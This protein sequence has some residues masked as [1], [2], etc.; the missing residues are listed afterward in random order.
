MT[1]PNR[2][3]DKTLIRGCWDDAGTRRDQPVS[4]TDPGV[5]QTRLPVHANP[6]IVSGGLRVRE[7]PEMPVEARRRSRLHHV[8]VDG[9]DT[10]LRLPRNVSH[11]L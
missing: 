4:F 3:T 5:C 2:R 6:R 9:R 8:G 7:P 1:R 10:R 11:S